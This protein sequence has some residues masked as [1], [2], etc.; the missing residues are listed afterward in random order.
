MKTFLKVAL[1]ILATFIA[2]KLA[3]FA[4]LLGCGLGAVAL[5]TVA[6]GASAAVAVIAIVIAAAALLA[7]V[8]LPLLAVCGIVALVRRHRLVPA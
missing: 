3:P 2:L 6:I 4:L 8:W 7:P 1:I 5:A